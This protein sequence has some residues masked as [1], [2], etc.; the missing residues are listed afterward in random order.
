MLGGLF[1]VAGY[2]MAEAAVQRLG[3]PRAPPAASEPPLIQPLSVKILSITVAVAIGMAAPVFL[4]GLTQWQL[5]REET[6]AEAMLRASRCGR[7][8]RGRST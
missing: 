3:L 4:Y 6:R 2:L 8:A 7:R 5:L 1:A